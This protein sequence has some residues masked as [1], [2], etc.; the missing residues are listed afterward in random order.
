MERVKTVKDYEV[1]VTYEGHIILQ[2]ENEEEAIKQA[3]ET[4]GEETGSWEMAKY[5]EY[6]IEGELK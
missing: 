1:K 2:A 6:E 4:F 5:A 3:R